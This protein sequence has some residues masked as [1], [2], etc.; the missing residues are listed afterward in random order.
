MPKRPADFAL[1]L[2]V[3]LHGGH[4]L[5]GEGQPRLAA[6]EVAD[7]LER[8]FG[9]TFT[10]QQV[11]SWLRRLSKK[12]LPP[13]E[14]ENQGGFHFYWLTPWGRNEIH[15]KTLGLQRAMDWMY[16]PPEGFELKAKERS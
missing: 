10:A 3:A 1:V 2:A 4:G 13:V 15:N 8:E 7:V 14:S 6:D 5:S 11:G 16:V 9:F 12:E